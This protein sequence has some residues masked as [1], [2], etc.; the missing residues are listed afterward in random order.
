[1]LTKSSKNALIWAVFF[2]TPFLTPNMLD[3]WV[4]ASL[5]S[6]AVALLAAAWIH[7]QSPQQT[8][9]NSQSWFLFS[10][11]LVPVFIHL[12]I[13]DTPNP[14][15]LVTFS[16]YIAS[17][18]LIFRMYQAAAQELI[19]QRTWVA[20]LAIVGNIY[21]LWGILHA[22]HVIPEHQHAFLF[23]WAYI[24]NFVGPLQQRNLATLFLL[25]VIASLWIQS[26]REG[27]G[28]AW[29][30]ASIVPCAIVFISNSR[31]ALLLLFGL[32]FL[33][34]ILHSRKKIFLAHMLPLLTV[35]VA[36]SILWQSSLQATP[37]NIPLLGSRLAEAGITP[38][39]NIW[40][41]SMLMFLEYPWFGIGAGNMASYF[42]EFQGQTLLQHP[43]WHQM[44]GAIFWSH[45]IAIQ[46]FAEGGIFGGICI[47]LFFATVLKRTYSILN[48]QNPI[49]HPSFPAAIIV[50]LLLLHG[51]ISI[52][53]LQGFFL[54]LLGLY[55][56]A[57]FPVIEVKPSNI[58]VQKKSSMLYLIPAIY[59]AFT[60]YQYIHIQSDVRTVFDDDPSSPR[61]IDKVSVAIDNPWTARTGL[62]YLFMNMMLSH[63]P[64]QQWIDLYPYLYEYWHLA[65]GPLGLKRLILQAHLADNPLSEAYLA[66]IYARDFPQDSWN[67][68]LQQHIHGGHQAYEI[69]DIQ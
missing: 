2:T 27:W 68:V 40:Y 54:A 12:L 22:F 35:S 45:N 64:K 8:K 28:K 58:S 43:D 69:L 38:R 13:Q 32:L 37:E 42:P 6:F 49:E 61:F 11:F 44:G 52:S 24:P 53:L 50:I 26:I 67:K 46:F 23:M 4:A 60:A 10:L 19:Q 15:G 41:S 33:L 9:A 51:L 62:E 31:A 1:M 21:A 5:T 18:F 36:I 20:L 7:T 48:T 14:W 39:L 47:I 17:L 65:K 59:M 63:S 25:I 34:F 3:Y 30:L 66:T 57:L 56:A 55:L 16:I 29:L